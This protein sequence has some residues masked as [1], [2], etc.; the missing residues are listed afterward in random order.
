MTRISQLPAPSFSPSTSTFTT[1]QP[2]TIDKPTGHSDATIRY[3]TDGSNPTS[4]STQY[5]SA[6]NLT[7]TTTVEAK[8]FKSGYRDSTTASAT[9]TKV[10]PSANRPPVVSDFKAAKYKYGETPPDASSFSANPVEVTKGQK[11]QFK[12]IVTDPDDSATNNGKIEK[13][14][15]QKSDGTS[16]NTYTTDV[17]STFKQPDSIITLDTKNL[18][19]GSHSFGLKATDKSGN[20]TTNYTF[21]SNNIEVQVKIPKSRLQVLPKLAAY[22]MTSGDANSLIRI[23]NNP[24][25]I[26]NAGDIGSLMDW[27][28][29]KNYLDWMDVIP[30]SGNLAGGTEIPLDDTPNK[31]LLSSKTTGNYEGD[32]S[33]DAINSQDKTI[34]IN[35][36]QYIKYNLTVFAPLTPPATNLQ[37]PCFANVASDVGAVC[38]IVY[39][40]KTKKPIPYATVS[41]WGVDES[42]EWIN[43]KTVATRGDGSYYL[44]LYSLGYIGMTGDRKS[45]V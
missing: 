43:F 14:E 16:F 4:S 24:S 25:E 40:Q 41:F 5:S 32:I 6:L 37:Q 8:A 20:A 19:V 36:P 29:K 27:S 18:S 10:V 23:P 39:D 3:T 30:A 31:T 28:L 1:S 12:A 7:T 9:Y 38:G 13:V 45:V 2:V 21:S 15:F 35:S 26:Q 42:L 33:V 34:F 17:T 11:I 22:Y 44:P